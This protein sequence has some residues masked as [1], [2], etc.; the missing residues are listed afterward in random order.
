MSWNHGSP[1]YYAVNIVM[2]ILRKVS[3]I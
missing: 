3:A 2:M 1:K